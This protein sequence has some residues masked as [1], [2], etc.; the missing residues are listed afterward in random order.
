MTLHRT[1]SRPRG[2]SLLEVLIAILVFSFGL[3]GLAGLMIYS[4]SSN[5]TAYLRTQATFLARNMADRMS[6]N[7]VGMWAGN[8]NIS[9][10]PAAGAAITTTCATGCPPATLATHDIEVWGRQLNTFLPAAAGTIA[11]VTTGLA[12]LPNGSQ[13]GMRPPYA[14]TCTMTLSW[15]EASSTGGARAPHSFQWVFQP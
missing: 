5:H 11:C 15:N 7:P 8:Y 10:I 14:G 4:I 3:I 2:F 9:S 13:V 12:Y 1:H 6:A